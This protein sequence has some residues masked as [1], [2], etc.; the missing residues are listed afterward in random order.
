MFG[1]AARKP[2]Q[3]AVVIDIDEE[4]GATGVRPTSVGHGQGP[5]SVAVLGDV[6]VLDVATVGACLSSTRLQV[7]ERAI[8]RAACA[9]ST[10]FGILRVRASELVHEPWDD[11]V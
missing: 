10:T 6:L 2:I 11:T 5:Y 1:G 3:V 7:F 8:G 9:R 4:L